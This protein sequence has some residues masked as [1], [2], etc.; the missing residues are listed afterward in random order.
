MARQVA[1]DGAAHPLGGRRR[2]VHPL[3]DPLLEIDDPVADVADGVR[4]AFQR[5]RLVSKHEEL[6]AGRAGP[7]ERDLRARKES[8]PPRSGKC[9]L[10]A[11]SVGWLRAWKQFGWR[12]HADEAPCTRP[13][14]RPDGQASAFS[15]CRMQPLPFV[16]VFSLSGFSWPDTPAKISKGGPRAAPFFALFESSPPIPKAFVLSGAIGHPS[17][18][19]VHRLPDVVGRDDHEPVSLPVRRGRRCWPRPPA[20]ALDLEKVRRGRRRRP[21]R[22]GRRSATSAPS[23]NGIPPSRACTPGTRDGAEI[24]HADPCRRRRHAGRGA[25]RT[26]RRQDELHLPDSKVLSPYRTT[27]RRCR[28]PS[29]TT[30]MPRRSGGGAPSRPRAR[31]MPRHPR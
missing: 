10:N 16:P 23:P 13:S 28:S 9:H 11:G 1:G 29:T 4:N 27:P 26:R 24:S 5:G 20:L 25:R 17:A 2:R 8:E 21:P 30:A 14:P 12:R 19:A 31:A 7:Q 15:A 18:A 3:D 6:L 22:S